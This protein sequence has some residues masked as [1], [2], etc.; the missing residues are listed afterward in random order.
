[1]Y[2]FKFID[3]LT[4]DSQ[5][6]NIGAVPLA[7]FL[8][9]TEQLFSYLY[10][11]GGV[12]TTTL[13]SLLSTSALT[14]DLNL[15]EDISTNLN[16]L[17]LGHGKR[18]LKTTLP[19]NINA[20]F[21]IL[22]HKPFS[23]YEQN[24]NDIYIDPTAL[25]TKVLGYKE[26]DSSLTTLIQWLPRYAYTINSNAFSIDTLQA[27]AT[28]ASLTSLEN[29]L[30]FYTSKVNEATPQRIYFKKNT[31]VYNKRI[32][33]IKGGTERSPVV[34]HDKPVF[35]TDR[36]LQLSHRGIISWTG[37]NLG[38]ASKTAADSTGTLLTNSSNIT[39]RSIDTEKGLVLL[40]E[41]AP[42]NIEFSYFLDTDN[43]AYLNGPN[44]NKLHGEIPNKLNIKI[45]N[46]G[47]LYYSYDSNEKYIESSTG[48]FDLGM[49]SILAKIPLAA[50]LEITSATF[51]SIDVRQEG[52]LQLDKEA[53]ASH[54]SYGFMGIEPAQRNIVII[55]LP[56]SVLD[57]LITQFKDLHF[58]ITAANNLTTLQEKVE[59]I[60]TF[61]NTEYD[62]ETGIGESENLIKEEIMTMVK[63]YIPLGV[64][65]IIA[66]NSDPY[67]TIF[68]D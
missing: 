49:Q 11:E 53:V 18:K 57:T 10:P 2:G 17:L 13:S 32:R 20:V 9:E 27:E 37:N 8:K 38:L 40:K 52:G 44:L 3:Q 35:L 4:L 48:S 58:D 62:A 16:Y 43:W 26:S 28:Y 12:E 21:D 51:S 33:K 67:I 29:P 7:A 39:I 5:F 63:R 68:T 66:T 54:T 50:T 24:G 55:K 60:T 34:T 15:A 45:D 1:M 64:L 61:S 46:D 31:I 36:L 56:E 59:Y 19:S 25:E 23:D 47:T 41:A 42:K 6:N 65:P 22:T 30:Q 14:F